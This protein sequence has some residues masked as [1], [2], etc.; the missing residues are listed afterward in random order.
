MT[1]TIKTSDN[2]KIGWEWG[3]QKPE[4]NPIWLIHWYLRDAEEVVWVE[5][6]NTGFLDVRIPTP[7]RAK[8]DGLEEQLKEWIPRGHWALVDVREHE[9]IF[10]DSDGFKKEVWGW[11]PK[12][13]TAEIGDFKVHLAGNSKGEFLTCYGGQR[14]LP[15]SLYA[16]CAT[17]SLRGGT[18]DKPCVQTSYGK[19]LAAQLFLKKAKLPAMLGYSNRLTQD[20]MCATDK[21][22][23]P[24]ECYKY[25]LQFDTADSDRKAEP[26]AVVTQA[27]LLPGGV[28][29][30]PASAPASAASSASSGSPVPVDWK[31]TTVIGNEGLDVVD[32][33][34][35][36]PETGLPLSFLLET[37]TDEDVV[38]TI[39][40]YP[41]ELDFAEYLEP[42]PMLNKVTKMLLTDELSITVQLNTDVDRNLLSNVS[43]LL[44][45]FKL[46]IRT[47][48]GSLVFL[49]GG[50][51]NETASH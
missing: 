43:D 14:D 42:F 8:M 28:M 5:H 48:T 34:E 25:L 47:N 24:N 39:F 33:D 4:S 11:A 10:T 26:P 36:I 2:S 6:L 27:L 50:S 15:L 23:L 20:L 41:V 19:A 30:A 45:G 51:Y 13:A 40:D 46:T 44:E 16:Q 17:W 35:E 32:A 3:L 49:K 38:M 1:L 21:V 9:V 31:K 37:C 7:G 22:D 29:A 18:K 12:F